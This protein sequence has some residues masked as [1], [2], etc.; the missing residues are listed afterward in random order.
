M[1]FIFCA[2]GVAAIYFIVYRISKLFGISNNTTV[3]VDTTY[4]S[5]KEIRFKIPVRQLTVSSFSNVLYGLAILGILMGCM[6]VA[7]L[8]I[9]ILQQTGAT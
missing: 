4:E 3:L 8:D 9:F 5:I 7:F 6:L 1:A 2:L